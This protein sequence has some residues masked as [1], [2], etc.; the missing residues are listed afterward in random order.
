VFADGES[1]AAKGGGLLRQLLGGGWPDPDDV[2][3]RLRAR[4]TA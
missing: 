4:K 3:R 2:V 1:I